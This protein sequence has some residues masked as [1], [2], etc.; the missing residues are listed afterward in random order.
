MA[1]SMYTQASLPDRQ[2]GATVA[3]LAHEMTHATQGTW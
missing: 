2:R 1:R 3:L